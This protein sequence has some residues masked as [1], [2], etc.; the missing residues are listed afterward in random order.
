MSS[1]DNTFTDSE[2]VKTESHPDSTKID[3][4]L[5]YQIE[6][7][8]FNQETEQLR[9][10]DLYGFSRRASERLPML[11]AMIED[12]LSR[13]IYPDPKYYNNDELRQ[14]RDQIL[15]NKTLPPRPDGVAPIIP[16]KAEPIFPDEQIIEPKEDKSFINL[17]P[18]AEDDRLAPYPK[19][20]IKGL[21]E[22]NTDNAIYAPGQHLKSFIALDIS[23]S[24]ATGHLAFWTLVRHEK[25]KANRTGAGRAPRRKRRYGR[26]WL[27]VKQFSGEDGSRGLGPRSCSK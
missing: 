12:L 26:R 22:E 3:I 9:G 27:R 16:E 8:N 21:I 10:K 4:Q 23:Y 18:T 13:N 14:L 5:K 2:S 17:F 1:D 6:R 20:L 25:G 15:K 11:R 19:W 7:N 24:I